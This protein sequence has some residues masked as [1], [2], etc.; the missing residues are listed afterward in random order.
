MNAM[1]QA[2][3]NFIQTVQQIIAE[4]VSTEVYNVRPTW[5]DRAPAHTLKISNVVIP[6][7]LSKE[8]PIMTL[9]TLTFQPVLSEH[10]CICQ[11]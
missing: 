4:G 5:P 3:R 8:L 9:L 6:S 7:D 11:Q 2:D 10:L 1:T